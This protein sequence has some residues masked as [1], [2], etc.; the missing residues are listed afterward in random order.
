M[1]ILGI[2]CYYHDSAACLVCD[3]K[4]VAAA[5]EER[6]NRKKHSAVFPISAVNFCLNQADLTINDIDYIVFHEKPYLKF[7]RVISA[8]IHSFPRSAEAFFRVLPL[9]LGERL[10]FP[11]LLKGELGYGN[12]TLFSRHHLSH[13]ASAFLVSPFER[14]VI[15]T[16]DGL[17][18]MATLTVGIGEGNDIKMLKQ[19]NYPNSLGLL[20]S[21]LTSYLGFEVNSGEGKV[22]ALAD[23]GEPEFYPEFKKIVR[24]RDDGSFEI[25]FRYFD[26]ESGGLMYKKEF[27][28]IFGPPREKNGELNSKHFNLAATLQKIVE[29]CVLTIVGRAVS[30]TGCSNVCLAGGIFLNCVLNSKILN[31]TDVRDIYIQPAAGDTGCALGAALLVYNVLMVKHRDFVMKS[32]S[33]GPEYGNGEIRMILTNSGLK[34]REMEEP[35]LLKYLAAKLAGGKTAGWFRGRMEFGPRALGNRS[36]LADPRIPGMRD[37]LNQNVKHREWFRPYGVS[38]LREKM[39]QW[40]DRE[41]T[42]PFML[43]TAN[44]LTEKKTVIPSAVHINGSCRVQTVTCDDGLYYDLIRR[45]DEFTGVPMLINTSFNDNHE[46]IVCTP[47]DALKCFLSTQIDMLVL[48]NFVIEK[49]GQKG[50]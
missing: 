33:L 15:V 50:K 13:A 42:N 46:P 48:N 35:Q 30:E 49:D 21:A 40:F 36:I 9:Y 6:F 1:N 26:F 14:A 27:V 39:G 25:D 45:F 3:G 23:Y 12:Q 22:M 20:Y 17:G 28:R 43:Q 47:E 8:F 7:Y 18:E 31:L 16:A 19:L 32:A 5:Q 44:V 4:V 24:I 29:D 34:Y 11:L 10:I 2:S 38:V 37:H 41:F